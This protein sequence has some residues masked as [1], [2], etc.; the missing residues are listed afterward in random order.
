M[1]K[2]TKY[3][4]V[5]TLEYD[6]RLVGHWGRFLD[7]SLQRADSMP[8]HS[9]Q[10]DLHL[11]THEQ[12]VTNIVPGPADLIVYA[13]LLWGAKWKDTVIGLDLTDSWDTFVMVRQCLLICPR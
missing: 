11:S 7:A 1:Q 10:A 3:E 9:L 5:F 2:Y 8:G 13:Q 4:F 12:N 6:V